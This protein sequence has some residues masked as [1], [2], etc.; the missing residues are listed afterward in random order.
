MLSI[1]RVCSQVPITSA[2]FPPRTREREEI[3]IQDPWQGPSTYAEDFYSGGDMPNDL[4]EH[5]GNPHLLPTEDEPDGTFT[6]HP[7]LNS[8]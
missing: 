1:C 7:L 3:D 8:P 4:L 2:A 5:G 6:F